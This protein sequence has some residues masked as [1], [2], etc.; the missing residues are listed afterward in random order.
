MSPIR[1]IAFKSWLVVLVVV[2]GLGF[3]GL[4]SL[5]IGWF[6]DVEGVAG[7]VTDLGYGAL[8]GIILTSGLVV[9]LRAPQDKIA[10]IQQAAL[11]IPALVMGSAVAS[12]GQDLVSALIVTVAVGGLLA[13]HPARGEFLS[14]GS[15]ISPALLAIT[16]LG[17]IPLISYALEMGAQARDL[18]GPPHHVQR[19]STMAAMAIAIVLVGMLA[20]MKTRGWRIPAWS[21]GAAAITFGLATLAF[22]DNPGAPGSGW[23]MLA[24]GGG[25]LFIAAAEREARRTKPTQKAVGANLHGSRIGCRPT[26]RAGT[27]GTSDVPDIDE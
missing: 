8:I 19:L 23:G 4:T 20:A 10:G 5:V 21:A 3:F 16:I 11:V 7:P 6:A 9:Q 1:R 26:G 22:T 12:D 18:E 27:Q 14:K 17:A 2:F 13:L 25:V 24:V 15:S